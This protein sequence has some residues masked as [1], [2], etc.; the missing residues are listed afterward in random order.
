MFN[1]IANENM[2]IYRRPRTWILIGLLVVAALLGTLTT[3]KYGAEPNANWQAEVQEQIGKQQQK[4]DKYTASQE[5]GSNQV[6]KNAG[7]QITILQYR[8]DHDI[9]PPRGT[10]WDNVLDMSELILLITIFTVIIAGDSVASEFTWGTIKIL[11]IRPASRTKILASKYIST[12]LFSLLMLLILFAVNV[13]ASGLFFGFDD[14]GTPYLKVADGQ[15]QEV[16]MA[17]HA[18]GI[19]ALAC[20]D[21]VMYV[22]MAFMI[23]SVFRSSSLGIGFAVFLMFAGNVLIGLLIGMDFEGAKY[24]FFAN[25]DLGDYLEG[26]P[27]LEGMTMGFSITVLAVYLVGFL[28][29]AWFA[30]T[31]RDV[32]A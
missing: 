20:V 29:L 21:L 12:L 5:S 7:H 9:A 26:A 30:F 27:M 13:I 19:Y 24:L 10:M 25:T 15:V 1:L 28:A 11:L 32:A 17:L 18:I 23:S 31:R 4:I 14:I 22:S 2:K 3:W 6:I 16:S 8:L